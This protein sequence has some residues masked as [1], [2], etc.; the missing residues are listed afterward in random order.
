MKRIAF[1]FFFTSLCPLF[2]ADKSTPETKYVSFQL[3]T[4]PG[5]AVPM[6]FAANP[7]SVPT[8]AQMEDFVHSLVRAIGTTGDARHKLAFA[9]THLRFDTTDEEM[10]RVIHDAFAVA[11]EN[12]VAVV[13]HLDDSL[14]WGKRADLLSNPDN[15]ETADW[16]Q[17][18]STGRRV[19]WSRTPSK[20]APQ[21]CFNSPAIVAAVKARAAL[22]G[23]EIKKELAEPGFSGREYLL[24]GVIAGSETEI[25]R[26]FDT[27]RSLGY[28]ALSHRGFSES[29]PPK[30]ANAERVGVV[31]EW[32]E[33][34]GNSLQ[35]AGIPSGKVFCHIAFT[36]Q[37]LDKKF[38]SKFAPASVAFSSAY[39][40]GFSTYPEGDA[41]KRI[42]AAVA[43]HG[44][45]GW[46]SAE[47][48]NVSPTGM[49]GEPNMETYLA[50]MFNHGA[51]LVNVFSWGIGGEAM[52]NKNFFRKATE[53]PECLAAYAKFLRGETLVESAPVGFSAEAFQDKMHRI[54][55]ELPAWVQQT[56]RQ[57]EVMSR[58]EKIK[59]CMK[60]QKWEEADKLAM[61]FSRW[62]APRRRATLPLPAPPARRMK[63]GEITFC[64]N[65]AAPFL[66]HAT[67]CRRT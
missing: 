42:F 60:K 40:P 22:I 36:G 4:V 16:K 17:I 49:P 18:P 50:K 55:S 11:R 6:A 61:R 53:S 31:K 43:E 65:S 48:A 25:G 23:A 12:D 28:R 52:R 19:D 51:V 21:M 8:K 39:R 66:F 5:V 38:G 44:S 24:A 67:R 26:D 62:W 37:G 58:I 59:A 57:A 2:A 54:Q 13:F 29:H 45:P 35:A 32:I 27:D 30:D 10:R 34:W 7:P 20:F 46:I 33:L 41:F 56:G 64:T 14:Y 15:I 1:I 63:R 3:M 47:G 9:P